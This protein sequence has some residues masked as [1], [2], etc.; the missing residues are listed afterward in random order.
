MDVVILQL[1]LCPDE[2]C[3]LP[4]EV[5][6]R[7]VLTS[8]SGPIEHVTIRCVARHLFTVPVHR[9]APDQVPVTS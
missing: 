6:D 8:T 4:A 7:F 9:L 2:T 5:A 1:T 3:R